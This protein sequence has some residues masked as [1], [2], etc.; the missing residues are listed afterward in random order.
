VKFARTH[1]VEVFQRWVRERPD[2]PALVF[3]EQFDGADRGPSLTYAELDERVRAVARGLVRDG[4]VG[5][6]VLLLHPPGAEFAVA[7]LACLYAGVVAVPAPPPDAGGRGASRL[8][9]IVNDAGI[10]CVLAGT[11]V[12]PAVRSWLGDAGL[13]HRVAC[14]VEEDLAGGAQDVELPATD[15]SAVAFLQY[16]SGSTS[17]PKGV[18]VTHRALAHNQ[19]QIARALRLTPDT[20]RGVSWLP[21]YHDMGLLGQLLSPLFNGG[22]SYSMAPMTFL[23]R[24]YRWLQMV[25]ELRAD[26]TVGPDFA[27]ALA[28]QRITDEQ[29]AELDLSCL[30]AALNGSEPIHAATLDRFV[31]RFAP[32]GLRRDVMVPCYGMAETTLM[33]TCTPVGHGHLTRDV[34]AAALEAHRLEPAQPGRRARR[35]VSSGRAVDLKVRV[36]DPA[37]GAELPDGTVGEIWISGASVAAGYWRRPTLTAQVFHARVPGLPG[38]HLRTGDL[39]TLVGGDLFVTGRIKE[40]LILNGRNLYPQDI[41]RTMRAAHPLAAAGLT[42]VF[43]IEDAGPAK[44]AAV[45]VAVQEVRPGDMRDIAADELVAALRARV[46]AEH[47]VHLGDVVLV[48]T[49]SVARTTSGKVQRGVMRAD[50]LAGALRALP[51]TAGAR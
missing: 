44:A 28:T 30:R 27:Y 51:A 24:P 42:A 2:H 33:V 43:T 32:A 19:Q 45:T 48:P 1:F 50:Y 11:P 6:R 8:A 25:S 17:E 4:L 40:M 22:T 23:K 3:L 16:T 7:L 31:E 47:D 15:P 46:R 9:G 35:L 38:D 12:A 49:G 5:S 34:D 37:T 10:G 41:E 14:V 13:G 39:G 36:V 21:H 18:V 26:F 20:A 29:L